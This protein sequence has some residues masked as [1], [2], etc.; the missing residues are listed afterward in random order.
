[1]SYASALAFTSTDV[2]LTNYNGTKSSIAGVRCSLLAMGVLRKQTTL[3][4]THQNTW[5][6]INSTVMF[7]QYSSQYG[8]HPRCCMTTQHYRREGGPEE[9]YQAKLLHYVHYASNGLQRIGPNTN[10]VQPNGTNTTYY[11]CSSQRAGRMVRG[12]FIAIIK[13]RGR[14]AILL[15]V[16][17]IR[18]TRR[19]K[20]VYTLRRHITIYLLQII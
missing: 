18:Y 19:Y 3:Y 8:R 1:M 12:C 4:L 10:E 15:R 2:Q 20:L 11:I 9:L 16:L 5:Y 14:K 6:D 17:H 7:H 13:T